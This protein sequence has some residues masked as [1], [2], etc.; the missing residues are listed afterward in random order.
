MAQNSRFK[1]SVLHGLTDDTGKVLLSQIFAG[2]IISQYFILVRKSE[3]ENWGLVR[4]FSEVDSIDYAIETVKIFDDVMWF[5]SHGSW[6]AINSNGEIVV[7]GEYSSV[8]QIND[9]KVIEAYKFGRG[10]EY[11][12]VKGNP[13]DFEEAK[14]TEVGEF[15]DGY[16]IARGYEKK[17]GSEKFFVVSGN[18]GSVL[19]R[20]FDEA[21]K[22]ILLLQELRNDY[23][24]SIIRS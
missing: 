4:D 23:V 6:K 8:E 12:T 19:D 21:E 13:L 18:T 16:A 2:M 22:C 15:E 9:S 1:K 11:F 10:I 17:T 20:Y 7:K 14:I 5:R 3:Q 24:W